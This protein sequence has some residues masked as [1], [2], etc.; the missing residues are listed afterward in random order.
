M[1][2]RVFGTLRASN[3]ETHTGTWIVDA[4]PPFLASTCADVVLAHLHTEARARQWRWA[5][6]P[7]VEELASQT[8]GPGQW[9]IP[10]EYPTDCLAFLAPPL[11]ADDTAALHLLVGERS[12]QE[13]AAPETGADGRRSWQVVLDVIEPLHHPVPAPDTSRAASV[14]S[15]LVQLLVQYGDWAGQIGQLL[16][17]V[18]LDPPSADEVGHELAVLAQLD[19]V[20][21]MRRNAVEQRLAKRAAS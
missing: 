14:R 12:L 16:D 6:S 21:A 8:L 19:R 3:G 15:T 2:H 9:F 11:G 20:I 17:T 4:N 5:E 7:V 18:S 10:E 13:Q 1:L